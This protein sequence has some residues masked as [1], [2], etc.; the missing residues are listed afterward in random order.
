MKMIKS[1]IGKLAI[2]GEAKNNS[3]LKTSNSKLLLYLSSIK[4]K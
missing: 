3:K 4:Q 2:A 1:E